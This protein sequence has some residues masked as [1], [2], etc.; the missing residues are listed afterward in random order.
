MS[1]SRQNHP[2]VQIK[3]ADL[4]LSS[5]T[6]QHPQ[7]A[8]THIITQAGN[9]HHSHLQYMQKESKIMK[10]KN[11]FTE[12]H[13]TPPP[14]YHF[15]ATNVK[16]KSPKFFS[17]MGRV[18]RPHHLFKNRVR[19]YPLKNNKKESK[20]HTTTTTPQNNEQNHHKSKQNNHKQQHFTK[21]DRF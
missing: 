8:A 18:T 13:S 4:H 19:G 1:A 2:P 6:R 20:H 10:M 3:S 21:N 16:Q 11:L 12:P 14:L 7:S 17:E 5:R 9:F 15:R